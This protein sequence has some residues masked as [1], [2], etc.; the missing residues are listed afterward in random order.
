MLGGASRV[1]GAEGMRYD[2]PKIRFA[3]YAVSGLAEI[4]MVHKDLFG[5]MSAL[6]P[7]TDVLVGCAGLPGLTRSGTKLDRRSHFRPQSK[8]E[9]IVRMVNL[10][11]AFRI[12]DHQCLGIAFDENN[13]RHRP[14]LSPKSMS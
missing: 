4:A 2:K 13:R 1:L 11:S 5:A 14:T 12:S 6:L 10:I 8:S 3:T 9:R 7:G